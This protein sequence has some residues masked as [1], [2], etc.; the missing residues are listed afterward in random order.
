MKS[1][2]RRRRTLFRRVFR[3]SVGPAAGP[4]R[5]LVEQL[6]PSLLLRLSMRCQQRLLG[7]VVKAPPARIV[8]MPH[9]VP[10][11]P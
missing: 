6:A 9:V 10:V 2:R 1:L 5:G 4:R 3:L 8:R 11:A 7:V